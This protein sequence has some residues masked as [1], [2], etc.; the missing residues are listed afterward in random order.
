MARQS[1]LTFKRLRVRLPFR[2]VYI[3]LDYGLAPILCV[4]VLLAAS[5]IDVNFVV[6]GILGCENIRPYS[7][8]ILI[9]SLSYICTSLDFKAFSNI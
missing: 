4:A 2:Q 9:L 8:I 5:V 3:Q 1:F 6:R 7:I